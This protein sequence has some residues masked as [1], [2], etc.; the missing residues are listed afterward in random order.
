MRLLSGVEIQRL[1]SGI[2]YAEKQRH[3]FSFDLTVQA[4]HRFTGPG[5]LDFGGS[6]FTAASH[7]PIP[8][9][10]KVS[11]DKYGWWDLAAGIYLVRFNEIPVLSTETQA[12]VV[13]HQ[14]LLSAG[15]THPVVHRTG[16]QGSVEVPLNV[17]SMGLR[18]KENARVSTLLIWSG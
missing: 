2:V 14:R 11:D 1:L 4:V 6:E 16:E 7:V 10:K 18:I 5:S 17:G 15:A 8:P 9:E 12:L 13:P 3:E